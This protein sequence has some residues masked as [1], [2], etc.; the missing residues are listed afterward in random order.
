MIYLENRICI[1]AS[2]DRVWN[3]LAD[4]ENVNLWVPEILEAKCPVGKE[5]GR[6]AERSCRLKGNIT[7]EEKWLSWEE[8]NSF[9]YIATGM[10]IIKSAVNRW[11]LKEE[12]SGTLVISK[13]EI[14]LCGGIVGNILSSLM[15]PYLRR[16]GPRTLALLK[17]WVEQGVPYRG[18][19]SELP[20]G[21]ITC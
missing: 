20:L 6:Y 16:I 19:V 2:I 5:K 1:V 15:A 10:P 9:S 13:A 21:P 3:A 17:Y 4:L 11:E 8:L 7:I 14:E 18:K 12:N